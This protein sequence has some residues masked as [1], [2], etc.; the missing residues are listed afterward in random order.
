MVY[1][2]TL[3][4]KNN[5]DFSINCLK[6]CIDNCEQETILEI[7]EDGSITKELEQYITNRIPN[8]VIVYKHKRDKILDSLLQGYPRSILFR[9]QNILADKVFDI[10]LYEPKTFFYLDTD[11]IF[12]KKFSFP[13]MNRDPVFMIDSETAYSFSNREVYNIR[14]SIFP[15][16]N[17]GLFYFPYSLFKV[18]IVEDF[19]ERNLRKEMYPHH[20]A[21]QTIFGFLVFINKPAFCFN[22]KEIVM[23]SPIINISKHTIAIHFS[24]PYRKSIPPIKQRI[25]RLMLNEPAV[26]ISLIPLNNSIS[27][28]PYL[29]RKYSNKILRKLTRIS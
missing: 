24:R 11:I 21:E 22:N 9:K 13:E 8:A 5:L 1:L 16:I 7:F 18:D 14:N 27:F 6:S 17:S 15:R 4:G 28:L 3:L 23:A 26:K 25:N 2:R 12:F 29:F 20:W 19:L 10:I